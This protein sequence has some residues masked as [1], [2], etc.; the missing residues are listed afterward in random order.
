M[1]DDFHNYFNIIYPQLSLYLKPSYDEEDRQNAFGIIAKVLKHTKVSVK[2]YVKQ[3]FE[4]I[5]KNL[6]GKKKIK[7]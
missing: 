7:K 6:S 4:D 2:F 3:L 1:Q 5:Q